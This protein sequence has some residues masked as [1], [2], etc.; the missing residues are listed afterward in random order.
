MIWHDILTDRWVDAEALRA[1]ASTAFGVPTASVAVVDTPEQLLLVPDSVLVI[2]ERT[3]EYREFP[4]QLMVVLRDDALET[5]HAGF[6]GV[7]N[8]ARA[9]ARALDV[10]VVFGDGPIEPYE[11]IRVR[12]SGD[13]D[14]VSLDSDDGDEVD[15]YFVYSARP[16]NGSQQPEAATPR[17]AG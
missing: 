1:A 5:R 6:D 10:S 8:V 9:L 11:S 3:R 4:L 17:H 13:L 16:F 15:S 7:L 14:V 12:P 2:L